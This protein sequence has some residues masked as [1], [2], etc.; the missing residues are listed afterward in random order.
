MRRLTEAT[1][2]IR[3][4]MGLSSVQHPLAIANAWAELSFRDDV[5]ARGGDDANQ[6]LL[7]QI[8]LHVVARP[9]RRRRS[10]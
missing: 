4:M 6:A 7:A 1:S 9:A 5:A 2:V 8:P 3:P 10:R